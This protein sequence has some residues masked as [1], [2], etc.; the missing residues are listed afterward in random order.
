MLVWCIGGGSLDLYLTEFSCTNSN[1]NREFELKYLLKRRLRHLALAA[2]TSYL[3]WKAF[4]CIS[5]NVLI[6]KAKH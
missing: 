5:V 6:Y 2:S 4:L 3:K 1:Q